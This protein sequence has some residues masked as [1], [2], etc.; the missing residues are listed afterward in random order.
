MSVGRPLVSTQTLSCIS[1]STQV[2]SL[3]NVMSVA[4]PSVTAR[5]SSCT[6]ASTLERSPMN[7]TSV[8]RPSVRAQTSPS[9]RESTQG[10]NPMNVANVEK[11]ST[12]THTLFCIG[13]FT[14]EKNLTSALSAARPSPGAQPSHCI[15]ES[16]PESEP[17][18]TAPPPWMH[19]EHS[20]KVVCKKNLSSSHF[21][22]LFLKLFQRCGP[23]EGKKRA[24]IDFFKVTFKDP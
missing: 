9:I 8:A 16:M 21:P 2:R 20:W 17:Q 11:L 1:E 24:L 23:M 5:I 14:L 19:S 3:M 15:T 18:N 7:V 22:L 6:S 4:K 10:R 12:E 13:G